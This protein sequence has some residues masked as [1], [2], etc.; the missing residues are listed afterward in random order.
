MQDLLHW[1][2]KPARKPLVLQGARQ[3]GKTHLLREFGHLNFDATVYVNLE[4]DLALAKEFEGELNPHRLLRFLETYTGTRIVEG[5]TLLILD[6]IQAKGRALTALKYF[7]E[8]APQYHVATA[9][10]LLGVSIHREEQ[11]FPVGR[12]ESLTLHPLDFEEFL[13]AQGRRAL[14]KAIREAYAQCKPLPDALHGL[15]LECYRSYLVT[16]GMPAVVRDFVETGS[17]SNTAGIQLGILD[18]YIADMAKY[19]TASESV[20]I[21]ASYN[22]LPSQLAKDNRKFQYKLVQRGGTAAIFGPS[23]DW[24]EFAGIV[25]KAQKLSVPKMPL[26]AYV[27]LPSFKLYMGDV[28]LLSMKAGLP[29][30]ILLSSMDHNVPFVGAITENYVAQELRARGRPLYYWESDGIAELDFILQEEDQIIP[31]EVKAG[32]HTR[33]R[34]LSVYREKFSPTQCIRLSQKNFGLENSILSVPLYAVFC[35]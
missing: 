33:S 5:K 8:Q 15:A 20:R 16:G 25:L 6:E 26:A 11:S 9:G 17:F 30:S 10:S 24:L 12:V 22:S 1:K 31:I 18:N 19:A 27:D 35:L 14:V 7:C 34:S 21:R 29:A 32:T 28:G 23:I 2:N 3:A 4:A 13:L